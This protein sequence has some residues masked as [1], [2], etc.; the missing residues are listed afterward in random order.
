MKPK[1]K[2]PFYR[3]IIP[4]EDQGKI[5]VSRYYSVKPE[6]EHLGVPLSPFYI[7][8]NLRI[9]WGLDGGIY[10]IEFQNVEQKNETT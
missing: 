1:T 5:I 6:S 4:I 2:P 8:C 9:D 10:K 7:E 3:Q